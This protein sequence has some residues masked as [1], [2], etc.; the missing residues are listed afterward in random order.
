MKKSWIIIIMGIVFASG[1]VLAGNYL[2]H[3]HETEDIAGLTWDLSGKIGILE[4]STAKPEGGHTSEELEDVVWFDKEDGTQEGAVLKEGAYSVLAHSF[5]IL[6]LV[7]KNGRWE[8]Y[9]ES[10]FVHTTEAMVV[11]KEVWINSK[12]RQEIINEGGEYEYPV[13]LE[14]RNKKS[15]SEEFSYIF[16]MPALDES[17]DE[18]CQMK[19]FIDKVTIDK[20]N[21]EHTIR[22]YEC[23]I[24]DIGNCN[25]DCEFTLIRPNNPEVI[26]SSFWGY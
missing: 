18:K 24:K 3:G 19:K 9:N 25:P 1:I 17:G 15:T 26:Y 5:I 21:I 2:I 6:N 12:I 10:L 20:D 13:I 14:I 22:T 23:P 7:F 16:E 11:D 4:K 8:I